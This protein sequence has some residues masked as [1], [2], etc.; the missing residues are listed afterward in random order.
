MKLS[1]VINP[2]ETWPDTITRSILT[3]HFHFNN[4]IMD[5]NTQNVISPAVLYEIDGSFHCIITVIAAG[6]SAE[7]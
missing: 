5:L 2:H 7:G 4:K 3:E 1:P 6:T